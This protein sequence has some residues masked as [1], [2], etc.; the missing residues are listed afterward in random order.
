MV[1]AIDFDGTCVTNDYP[2]IGKGRQASFRPMCH[3]GVGFRI[4]LFRQNI[5]WIYLYKKKKNIAYAIVYS[6][7]F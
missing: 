2:Y 1:I 3:N 5:I 6:N 7:R 4:P